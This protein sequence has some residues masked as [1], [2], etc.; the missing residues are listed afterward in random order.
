MATSK[1]RSC[2]HQIHYSAQACPS[3]GAQVPHKG[4]F[5]V[6]MIIL[7]GLCLVMLALMVSC[8]RI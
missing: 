6:L 5:R 3:C 1:C 8:A 7:G 2:D 4:Q